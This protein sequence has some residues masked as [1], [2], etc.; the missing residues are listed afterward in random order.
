MSDP[1]KKMTNIRRT[2]LK[3][4]IQIVDLIN[5]NVIKNTSIKI[6]FNL[7]QLV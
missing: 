3:N 6:R 5:A 7:Y 1:T 4:F 2:F